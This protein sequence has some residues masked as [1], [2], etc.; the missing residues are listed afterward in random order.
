MRQLTFVRPGV[1]EWQEVAP[2]RLEAPTDALVR[3]VVVT[4]CDLDGPTIRGETP[5]AGLGPF[6]FGHELV[7]EVVELGEAVAGFH[8]GQLVVVPFQ[9]SCGACDRCRAGLTA[10][11]RAVPPRSMFG[12]PVPVGG[13][14]GG[15]LSD[16][17]RVPFAGHMLVPVPHGI[18]P[19]A[20]ASA[21]D[22]LPDGWRTVGPHLLA[23]PGAPVLIVGGA[24]NSIPLYAAGIARALGAGRVDYLDTDPRRLEVARRL[25][26]ETIE[27]PP[28]ERIGEYPITVDASADPA[29]LACALRSLAPG[30]VCTS[31]GIYYGDAALPLL[32]MYGRGVRFHTGRANARADLPRVLAL[33]QA[34]RLHPEVVTS[35]VV[36]WD[37]AARALAE[38]SLKPV[39]VRERAAGS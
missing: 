35:E 15:A 32:D 12:F 22:N 38:P 4:T 28:P 16:L 34:G 36:P 6:A 14:W 25:G 37:D 24:A 10:N 31:I 19:E 33:V 8:R 26:A 18:A 13:A 2:P 29:G 1:L 27:G 39:F 3:P 11:C 21:S 7:A 23:D 20:I 30:G 9:I 5:L 17:M